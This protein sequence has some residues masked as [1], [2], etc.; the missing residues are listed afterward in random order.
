MIKKSDSYSIES[1]FKYFYKIPPY[2]REYAWRKDQ[3]ENLFNDILEN[4]KGYF[5]GSMI[6]INKDDSDIFEVI[7]G[8]QRLTTISILENALLKVIRNRWVASVD[9]MD[10]IALLANLQNSI[11]DKNSNLYKLELSIQNSNNIDYKYLCSNESKFE[12]ENYNKPLNFGNRR[13]SKAYNYFLD[14]LN[15]KDIEDNYIFSIEDIFS[16]LQNLNSS[17][18]VRIDV[19]DATSAFILFESIN[20]RG[21]PL[22]PIDLIKN[23]IIGNLEKIKKIAPE[24]TNKKWQSIVNNIEDYNDQIRF[25]RHYYHAFQTNDKIKLKKYSKATKSNIIKI[26]EEHIKNENTI[27][28]IFDELINKSKIYTKF[29]YPDLIEKSDD[30]YKYNVILNDLLHLGVA[31]SYSLLLYLFSEYMQKTDEL[32]HQ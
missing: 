10:K 14:R 24:K 13:I 28:F 19:K 23:L 27:E 12:K 25:L 15:E 32:G 11:Y 6:C 16:Y 20:N 9:D 17:L 18:L 4:E 8:Q 31:P 7:D 22:T 21:I 3:W 30:D 26:Y 1:I 5:L 2:Q 29:I